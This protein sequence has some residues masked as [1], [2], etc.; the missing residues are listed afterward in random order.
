MGIKLKMMVKVGPHM[1]ESQK[2]VCL[3][4]KIMK[5]T[6][7]VEQLYKQLNPHISPSVGMACG[8][9]EKIYAPSPPVSKVPRKDLSS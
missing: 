4:Q 9:L 3:I 1:W 5:P 8:L 6:E 7:K 2:P